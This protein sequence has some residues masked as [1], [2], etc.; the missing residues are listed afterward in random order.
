MIMSFVRGGSGAGE[1]SPRPV[2]AAGM[3]PLHLAAINR[4]EG[5]IGIQP[6]LPES[7]PSLAEI[8]PKSPERSFVTADQLYMELN[9]RSRKKYMFKDG[10]DGKILVYT[11]NCLGL[12]NC[13][14]RHK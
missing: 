8:D 2:V 10:K 11:K 9:E 3:T 5:V 4:D 1:V 12:Y 6:R 13:F 14:P 7:P